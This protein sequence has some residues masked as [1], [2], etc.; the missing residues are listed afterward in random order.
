MSFDLPR[1][2]YSSQGACSSAT[3][4]TVSAGE[5]PSRAHLLTEGVRRARLDNGLTLLLKEDHSVP[6]VTT[7][8]WYKVGSRLEQPASRG[9]S[10]LLEHLMFKGTD[11]FGKGEI[12]SITTRNG[13]TNNA[14]TSL[15]A[16]AY[17]FSFASDRWT[18]A[19]EIEASRMRSNTFDAGEFLLERQVV[20]EE[21]RMDLDTPW[22]ALRQQVE[23]HSL[24]RH[25]YR[26]PVIGLIEDL[27]GLRVERVRAFYEDFYAPNNAVLVL[28]GDFDSSEASQRIEDLFGKLPS[29]T[30]PAP[31]IPAE[32]ERRRPSHIRVKKRS[33]V[34]RLM[35]SFPAPAATDPDFPAALVLDK[36]LGEGKLSRLHKGLVKRRRLA[37]GVSTEI[38]E[39]LDPYL[40]FI[41]MELRESASPKTAEE[42]LLRILRRIREIDLPDEELD[43]AKSQCYVQLL[44]DFETTLDCASQLGLM[45]TLTGFEYWDEFLRLL[46]RLTPQDVRR[47]AARLFAPETRTVGILSNEGN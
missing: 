29:R 14:F 24:S 28:V 35:I 1:L 33:R 17:Y 15:D 2:P 5:L 31:E 10:H 19:L 3:G 40:F 36:V 44:H 41:R 30:P 16:T 26:Y 34:P 6:I 45:E 21:L 18:P 43:R 32:A 23:L 25:P 7:M 46:L 4:R 37:S 12:D 13:G 38:N 27:E 39:T 11:R 47:A 42:G 22:G 8:I 20:L 9:I